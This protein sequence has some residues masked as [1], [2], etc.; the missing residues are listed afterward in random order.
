LAWKVAFMIIGQ[1]LQ[2]AAACRSDQP[3][4]VI[5]SSLLFSSLRL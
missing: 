1:Q 3:C 4:N 2:F 5:F